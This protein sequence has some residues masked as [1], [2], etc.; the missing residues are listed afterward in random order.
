M[1]PR[2]E[3][4]SAA[5][6]YI[7]Q[8]EQLKKEG[9]ITEA[10]GSFKKAYKIGKNTG[11]S[12]SAYCLY[13]MAACFEILLDYQQAEATYTEAITI[14][15]SSN[16]LKSELLIACLNDLACLYFNTT[17]YHESEKLY[18][19][20]LRI[21]EDDC[22][23]LNTEYSKTIF[24]YAVLLETKA[25]YAEAETLYKK[26]LQVYEASYESEQESIA[27]CLNNI[28][29][30]YKTTARYDLAE[31]LYKRVLAI[32]KKSYGSK[33]TEVTDV[34]NKIGTLLE[35]KAQYAE[36]EALYQK[37]L[38]INQRIEETS[39]QS[40]ATSLNNI[41][42]LYRIT[43]RFVESESGFKQALEINKRLYGPEHP[44]VASDLNNLAGLYQATGR[45][46]KAEL[47]LN[48]AL[49]IEK[50]FWGNEHPQ[51]ATV[52]NNLATLYLTTGRYNKAEPCFER[53]LLINKKAY[54]DEHPRVATNLNN[55]ALLYE[56]TGRFSE[57]EGSYKSAISINEKIQGTAHPEVAKSLINLGGLYESLNRY[58]E[59]TQLYQR[60]IKIDKRIY[61]INHPEFAIDLNNLALLYLNMGK[62]SEAES[63]C[64]QVLETFQE[65]HGTDHGNTVTCLGNLARLYESMDRHH[66]AELIYLKAL[67]IAYMLSVPD[68]LW[69]IQYG[70]SLVYAKQNRIPSAILFGK[71]AVNTI[72]SIRFTIS[73]MGDTI[74]KSFTP[75]VNHAFKHLAD[76]L[77]GEGRLPEAE[78]V[79]NLLKKHEFF[80]YLRGAVPKT[81]LR[82]KTALTS[83]EGL[84]ERTHRDGL[85][86]IIILK[87]KRNA[88][89]NNS[90]KTLKENKQ[91]HVLNE[92]LEQAEKKYLEI[93]D[94]IHKELSRSRRVYRV[95][96]IKDAD[97]L[98]ETL[99]ELGHGAVALYPVACKDVFRLLLIAPNRRRAF[100]SH[101]KAK[102]FQQKIYAFRHALQ[103]QN[104]LLYDPLDLAKELYDIILGPATA[105]LRKLKAKTLMW[106]LEGAMRYIP[107]ST[108]HDGERY[109]VESYRNVMFT[110]ASNSR[111][112]DP[113]KSAWAG[114]GLGVTKEHQPLQTLPPFQALPM[115]R[116]ELCGIIRSQ[117]SPE[118]LF[119]GVIHMDESFTWQTMTKS[120]E[121]KYPLVHIA[122]HFKCA[123]GNDTTSFLLLG[124]GQPLYIHDISIKPNLF[125]GVDLLT[126]S[127]CNTAVGNVGQDGNEEECFAVL[128]QNQGAKAIVATLWP[129]A[130]ISTSLLMKE[131]YKQCANSELK[132]E[133][134]RKAQVA[135]LKGNIKP[136]ISSYELGRSSSPI[137]NRKYSDPD[138]SANL[139]RFDSTA[140]FAHPF[141]WA[142]FILIGNWK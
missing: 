58:R 114:L 3:L 60:A 130:D 47:L 33:S 123:P 7:V 16:D 107:M 26:A 52:L 108:L 98:M 56:K 30:L 121:K 79:M 67:R 104:G 122:S 44:V 13:M 28:A 132:A 75:I 1:K 8:G 112:K 91:L 14:T 136:D 54:G 135:L 102:E 115:V 101:I 43:G 32:F 24:S 134:L 46:K 118:G 128:A 17:R 40:I 59:A 15:E 126:L 49:R 103:L 36:A 99:E 140:P 62:Y 100:T 93:I 61:G 92:N 125:S 41:A 64:K 35:I 133:A 38:K 85:E 106:S 117:E 39:P 70:L 94:L 21:I 71:Q 142:P 11:G 90:R 31:K 53:T 137:Q 2:K 97:G 72:Q 81:H 116:E 82:E 127:A 129:V 119:D 22:L 42:G 66:D 138:T 48:K 86:N 87:K 120:L 74:L 65:L 80:Q 95:K 51:A 23:P 34:L 110:P 83:V 27:A 10:L 88:L 4:K 55:L 113:P 73:K 77:I 9:N 96:Q 139:F 141:F 37:A 45:Y 57:A 109:I 76:L 131:F 84:C 25:R 18:K 68:L 29:G 69:R 12:T 111:L 89:L 50:K 105:E 63:L 5:T 6:K 78:Q 19:R 124:N 20:A